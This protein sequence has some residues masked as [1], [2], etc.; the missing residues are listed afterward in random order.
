MMDLSASAN[1]SAGRPP[2]AR[3]VRALG[4]VLAHPPVQ[5][6]LQL[7]DRREHPV[8]NGEEL[9]PHRFV[10]PFHLPGRGRRVRR[11]QQVADAVVGADAVEHHRPGTRPEACRED[12]AVVRENLLGHPV[13]GQRL[14]QGLAYRACCRPRHDL[15]ADDEPRVVIDPG[16]DLHL[17][18]IGQVHPAH[19][20]HLPQLHRPAPLP[21]A[22]ILPPPPA[23]L[24]LD[25][26]MADQRPVH[27]RPAW[28][29]RRPFPLQLPP[30]PRRT[31]ARM[32][33]AQPDDPRLGH[34]SHLMRARLRPRGPV[35]QAAQPALGIPAQPFMNGLPRYPVPP[36]HRRDRRSILQDF[37][38]SPIPLLHDTQLHQ[39]TRLPPPRSP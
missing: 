17:D 16:H 29:R 20:V 22:V 30:D 37:K 25:Q 2:A 15:G 11:G 12:L 13:P 14:R 27:R 31:P 34:H 9:P 18:A 28:Q 23:F 21:P 4:V 39:H 10:Q 32:F 1:R 6:G 24:R 36:G 38:H 19:H 5:R 8:L 35:R 7:G 26:A 3:L 33:P